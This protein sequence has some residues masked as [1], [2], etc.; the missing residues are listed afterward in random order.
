MI[1]NSDVD[2]STAVMVPTNRILV[3]CQ[4]ALMEIKALLEELLRPLHDA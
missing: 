1:A 2:N 4:R 3:V